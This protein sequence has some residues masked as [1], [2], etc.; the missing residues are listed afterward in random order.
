[1]ARNA[2]P[3]ASLTK[4]AT[5]CRV[6]PVAPV[7]TVL[8]VPLVLRVCLV[9]MVAPDQLAHPVRLVAP[10]QLVRLVLANQVHVAKLV[11]QVFPVRRAQKA[12]PVSWAYVVISAL[13]SVLI[14]NTV[15]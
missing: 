15:I 12:T 4:S 1:M 13:R 2:R 6:R 3:F 8:P 14:A 7:A 11:N 10:V 9:P 5:S